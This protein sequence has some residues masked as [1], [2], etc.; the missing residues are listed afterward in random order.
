MLTYYIHPYEISNIMIRISKTTDLIVVVF[1]II[2]F[3]FFDGHSTTF[4]F[5]FIE[6]FH[7]VRLNALQMVKIFKYYNK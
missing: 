4:D 3:N 5:E 6:I 1:T 7:E 2:G